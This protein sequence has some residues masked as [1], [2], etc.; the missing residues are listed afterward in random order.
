[1][2]SEAETSRQKKRGDVF[3]RPNV[4]SPDGLQHMRAGE[5]KLRLRG[6]SGRS[7]MG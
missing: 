5:H 6:G 4:F 3:M 2:S 7:L 1:M